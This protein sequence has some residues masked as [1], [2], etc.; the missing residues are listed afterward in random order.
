M[1]CLISRDTTAPAQGFSQP[2]LLQPAVSMAFIK[3][4]MMTSLATVN[5]VPVGLPY[6]GNGTS[7]RQLQTSFRNGRSET[8]YTMGISWEN[9]GD[10]HISCTFREA[11]CTL[12][13][14][15]DRLSTA[16]SVAAAGATCATP[17]VCCGFSVAWGELGKTHRSHEL[18]Q[19]RHTEAMNYCSR[20][21]MQH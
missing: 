9:G 18:L 19:A 3:L 5:A 20:S 6:D 2:C 11:A 12:L 16:I 8:I 15:G 13:D 10:C 17:C 21:N 1:S 4:L 7:H 14:V